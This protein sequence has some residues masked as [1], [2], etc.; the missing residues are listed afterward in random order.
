MKTSQT[1]PF[2]VITGGPGSGKTT[3]LAE[4]AQRG[5][6]CVVEDA[7]ALIQEQVLQRGDALPWDNAPRYADL[8]MERSI[9]TWDRLAAQSADAPIFFDR[10]IGDA[11]TCAELIGHTLSDAIRAQAC[12]RRYRDPIFLAPWWAEIYVTDAE[13]RQS[14]EEAARTENA[15]EK[16]YRDLGYS[17]IMLPLT[18][19]AERADFV[20]HHLSSASCRRFC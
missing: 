14:R 7:R 17:V 6:T 19:P 5:Y 16:T 1:P 12:T 8:L 11:I 3:L 4:L 2:F 15:I 20:L 18:T 9:E 10:G 13:R